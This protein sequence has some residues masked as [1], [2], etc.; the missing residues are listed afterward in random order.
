MT[1]DPV[2]SPKIRYTYP[3]ALMR[4]PD[5]LRS[6]RIVAADAGRLLTGDGGSSGQRRGLVRD[7][8]SVDGF[9]PGRTGVAEPARKFLGGVA[10][11]GPDGLHRFGCQPVDRG[12]QGDR[13]RAGAGCAEE[14]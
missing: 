3:Q 10:D 4:S 1:A 8:G 14:R 9:A 6:R 2:G 7:L 12:A 5:V 13:A 11:R